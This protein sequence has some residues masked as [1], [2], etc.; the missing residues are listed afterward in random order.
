[1]GNFRNSLLILLALLLASCD[2]FYIPLLT[3]YKMD[4]R[5][6]NFVSFDMRQKLKVGMTKAQVRYVMGTPMINDPFHDN[7]WDYV[8]RLQHDRKVTEKQNL[9]LY[10]EGDNLARIVDGLQSSEAAPAN[11][12]QQG[13]G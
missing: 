7:R 3:P 9:T 10:F 2:S 5:Q 6:G 4:I 11:T 8:Y 1:M 13:K 12:D